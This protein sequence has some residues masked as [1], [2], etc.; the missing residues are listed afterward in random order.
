MYSNIPA[1][2]VNPAGAL[3]TFDILPAPSL[4]M[5]RPP[6]A[7]AAFTVGSRIMKRNRVDPTPKTPEVIC[8]IRK[9]STYTRSRVMRYPLFEKTRKEYVSPTPLLRRGKHVSNHIGNI[10]RGELGAI[11]AE[12]LVTIARNDEPRW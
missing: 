8:T 12:H 6:S 11:K 3:I 5:K 4:L 7:P 10:L 2:I 9:I 1:S